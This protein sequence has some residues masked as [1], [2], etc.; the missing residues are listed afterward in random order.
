MAE[1]IKLIF[2]GPVIISFTAAI[3]LFINLLV[4]RVILVLTPSANF[5]IL[6]FGDWP[7]AFLI[8]ARF[9]ISAAAMGGLLVFLVAL[10]ACRFSALHGKAVYSTLIFL[11]VLCTSVCM[12]DWLF[13]RWI[14]FRID[15][16]IFPFFTNPS[17]MMAGAAD[18]PIPFY[19]VLVFFL[20]FAVINFIIL[21]KIRRIFALQKV[22]FP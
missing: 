6:P 11:L 4:Y 18:T 15:S 3:L 16:R 17:L 2:P 9:D 5:P 8:G 7:L 10:I 14:S 13:Y 22:S 21:R 12:A 20:F 19:G 1:K